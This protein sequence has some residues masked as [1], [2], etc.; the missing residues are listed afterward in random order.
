MKQKKRPTP[1]GFAAATG[2]AAWDWPED[3]SHENGNYQNRCCHCER[4]FIGHKRRVACRVCADEWKAK[5]DAMTESERT[6]HTEKQR[7]EVA[8]WMSARQSDQAH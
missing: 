6:A 1:G 8:A 4:L 5:W 3:A 2:S 7:A